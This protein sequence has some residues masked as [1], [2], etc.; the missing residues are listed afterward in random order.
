MS[1][2]SLCVFAFSNFCRTPII[3]YHRHC[4]R[5]SYDLCLN[6]C[7]DIREASKLSVNGEMNQIA[8]GSSDNEVVSVQEM[9][10][11]QLNS[12]KKFSGWKANSNG[13][14]PCA[15]KKYGGCGSPLLV[16]KRIFKMNWVA[17]LVKNVEEMVGGCK[18]CNS[19]S[20]KKNG[21]D[22]RL[23]QAAQRTNDSDNLLYNPSSE[24]I[25]SEGIGDFRMHWRRGEPIIIKEVCDISTM[26]IW[27]PMVVWRGIKETAEEKMKDDNRTVKAIDCSDWTEVCYGKLTHLSF[28]IAS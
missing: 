2:H 25:K 6:C 3:D 27:D 17:K 7:K 9:S 28:Q 21:I 20:P 14:L 10:N 15:P 26:S 23:C 18:T 1:F 24:D 13:S 8:G 5:C 12:F 11:V 19:G 4:M 22:L 16:L